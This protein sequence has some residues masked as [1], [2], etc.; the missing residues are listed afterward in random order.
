MKLYRFLSRISLLKKYSAKVMFVAF[1]G[2]HVPLFGVITVLI[3]TSGST[4]N[5]ISFFLL[6]LGFT[7]LAAVVTLFVLNFLTSPV[8][9]IQL[10]LND[11]IE[12]NTIP[13]LPE[14]F[15][16]ELGLL[17]REVNCV[18]ANMN[19]SLAQKDQ[20]INTLTQGMRAPTADILAQLTLLKS[21]ANPEE[22]G[23]CIKKIAR[24]VNHQQKLVDDMALN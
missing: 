15:D 13:N 6:T 1:L 23:K 14:D 20:I 12:H 19:T 21:A 10:S 8:R 24:S 17:M 22:Q 11:Y 2:T 3:I 7:L 5:K 16:D 18:I 4:L 9:K